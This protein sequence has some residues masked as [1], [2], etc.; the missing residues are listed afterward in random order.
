MSPKILITRPEKQAQDFIFRLLA[1]EC[2]ALH[3]NDFMIEPMVEIHFLP[4]TWPELSVNHGIIITSTNA[5]DALLA[6]ENLEDEQCRREVLTCP[7][8]LVGQHTADQ[9]MK[10]GFSRIETAQPTAQALHQKINTLQKRGHLLYLRGRDVRHDFTSQERIEDLVVYDARKVAALS[11]QAQQALKNDGVQAV[12]FFSVRTALNFV[13]RIE[14]NELTS[15]LRNI[16]ALC[17]SPAV[18]ESVRACW[19]GGIDAAQTP[20]FEG[21]KTLV[22]QEIDESRGNS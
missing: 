15:A 5:L 19:P 10:Y 3:N 22:L 9:A 2:M 14:E 17:I 20:D 21:M 11:E 12:T 8:Y 4:F 1:Q 13:E 16:K 7:L 18:L 6:H